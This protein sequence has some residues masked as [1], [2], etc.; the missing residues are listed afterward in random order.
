MGTAIR[1]I[2]TSLPRASG[3]NHRG[4]AARRL[5]RF[6]E[7]APAIRQDV[8]DARAFNFNARTI[9]GYDCAAVHPVA[10]GG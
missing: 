9:P 5:V 6:G 4:A 10:S 8:R 7:F 3:P 1:V 2:V